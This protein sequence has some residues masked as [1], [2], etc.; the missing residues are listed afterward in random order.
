L[1]HCLAFQTQLKGDQNLPP[2]VDDWVELGR[3]FPQ[4]REALLKIRDHD[5]AEFAAGRGYAVLFSEL[6]AINGGWNEEDAT[7]ALFKTI[8]KKDRRLARQ[9]YGDA[10]DLLVTKGEYALCLEC[11]GD[12]RARFESSRAAFQRTT[13]MQQRQDAWQ[14]DLRQRQEELAKSS[15]FPVPPMRSIPGPYSL[16]GMATNHFV[17][18]VLKLEK[19]LAGAGRLDE[20]A[21]IRD[22][23][24][25][26]VAD[27]RFKSVI[28]DAQLK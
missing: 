25:A 17:G 22:Q 14:N 5:A 20:A 4:A 19:I 3:R 9:C 11:L 8:H 13:E 2:L 7:Y 28:T 6:K 12:P 15:H 24:L 26:L 18:T 1:K 21:I 16:G 27:D 23:A 10:E